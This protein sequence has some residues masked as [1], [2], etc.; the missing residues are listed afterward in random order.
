METYTDLLGRAWRLF[1]ANRALWALSLI[2]AICGR[3]GTAGTSVN[4]NTSFNSSSSEL[5]PWMSELSDIPA[6]LTRYAPLLVG[7]IAVS[8]IVGLVLWVVGWLAMGGLIVATD[9][10]DRDAPVT[11]G[12]SIGQSRKRLP[13]LLLTDLL[14]Q[15]PTL[16]FSLVMVTFAIWLLTTV[17]GA[18]GSSLS[19]PSGGSSPDPSS[20]TQILA[21]IFGSLFCIVPLALLLTIYQVIVRVMMEFSARLIVLRGL[22]VRQSIGEGWRLLRA[23]LGRAAGTWVLFAL[24]G[25]VAGLVLAVPTALLLSGAMLSPSATLATIGFAL[26]AMTFIIRGLSSAVNMLIGGFSSTLWTLIFRRA[27]AQPAPMPSGTVPQ[28]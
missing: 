22:G 27:A 28:V 25:A 2:A 24:I 20:F 9:A 23:N 6:L 3:F 18:L 1:R 19:D 10:A 13:T 4:S 11:F 21:P 7:L 14:L 15:I 5:P 12:A 8:V 26:L 16:V 17:L